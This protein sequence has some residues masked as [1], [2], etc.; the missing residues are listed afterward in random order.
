MT[1]FKAMIMCTPKK[2]LLIFLLITLV[3]LCFISGTEAQVACQNN[4][5][6]VIKQ[7][8]VPNVSVSS[9]INGYVEYLPSDYWSAPNKKFPLLIFI[10]GVG[11]IGGGDS[12]SLCNVAANAL[13][14]KIEQGTYPNQVSWAGQ[15]YSFIVLSPQYNAYPGANGNDVN[16]MLNYAIAHYRIDTTRIYLTGLSAGANIIMEYAAARMGTLHLLS[17]MPGSII[18]VSIA[19]RIM[20]ADRV[21]P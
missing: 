4:W 8:L 1:K 17:P 2:R 20:F 6:P 14:L 11:G 21:I 12:A 9:H 10:T 5:Y 13:P 7:R 19:L 18:G 15:S 16:A 3:N